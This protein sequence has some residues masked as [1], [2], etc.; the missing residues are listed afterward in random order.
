MKNRVF[1]QCKY[2][3]HKGSREIKHLLLNKLKCNA[4][5]ITGNLVK[6]G[7]MRKKTPH[8]YYLSKQTQST[9]YML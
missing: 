7:K 2:P 1:F 8:V 3:L 5:C 6:D 4:M 9:T